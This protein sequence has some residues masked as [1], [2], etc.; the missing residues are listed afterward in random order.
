[1]K[2]ASRLPVP[3]VRTLKTNSS[4]NKAPGAL[5]S[6]HRIPIRAKVVDFPWCFARPGCNAC[7]SVR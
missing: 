1:M 2:T 5:Y 4:K 6:H 3:L 7:S